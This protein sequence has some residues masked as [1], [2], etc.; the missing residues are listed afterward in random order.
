MKLRPNHV[1]AAGEHYVAAE[2]HG[3]G[4][5]A[6]PVTIPRRSNSGSFVDLS[7][8]HPQ[9]YK[10]PAQWVREDI[11]KAHAAWLKKLEANDLICRTV[12]DHSITEVRIRQCK[13]KWDELG[14]LPGGQE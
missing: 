4:G 12:Q 7:L 6:D 13:S 3:R 10:A 8:E 14:I 11:R 1:A 2:I 5:Y 9:F